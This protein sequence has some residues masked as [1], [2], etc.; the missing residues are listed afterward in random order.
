MTDFSKVFR[1]ERARFRF[2]SLFW[3]SRMR[4]DRPKTEQI[5]SG[6][7][8]EPSGPA[9]PSRSQIDV[10]GLNLRIQGRGVHAQQARSARLVSASLIQGAAD[11]INFKTPHFVIE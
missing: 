10:I 2:G 8:E 11:Q 7:V 3:T 4:T 1:R 9:R 5:E 6:H